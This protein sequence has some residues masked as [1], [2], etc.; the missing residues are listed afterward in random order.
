MLLLTKRQF[1]STVL[2]NVAVFT[3]PSDDDDD[4]DDDDK[5]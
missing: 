5:Y 1:N 3:N 2:A 4:D